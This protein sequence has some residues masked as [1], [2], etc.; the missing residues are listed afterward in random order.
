MNKIEI[1]LYVYYIYILEHQIGFYHVYVCYVVGSPAL[2][3][4]QGQ[5]RYAERSAGLQRPE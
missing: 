1:Y 5:Q 2:Y 4:S 3:R